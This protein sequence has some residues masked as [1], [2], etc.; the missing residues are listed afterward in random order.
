MA[1]NIEAVG[2]TSVT[3]FTAAIEAFIT[4]RALK[5]WYR[6]VRRANTH[7]LLPTLYR[8]P[9][10]TGFV[11]LAQLE[12][13]LIATFRHRSPP[14]VERLP[15][16]DLELLFLMQHHGMPT[17]LLDWSENPYAALFFAVVEGNHEENPEDSAVWVLDPVALNRKSL[18]H[19]SH[20]GGI[21]QISDPAAR[22][23][24][25]SSDEI[26]TRGNDNRATHEAMQ[27]SHL[28]R[29][30]LGPH[31]NRHDFASLCHHPRSC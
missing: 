26:G 15:S 24:R 5:L 23:F 30:V 7:T 20:R 19:M 4:E 28:R 1:A 21:I 27:L 10:F 2:V 14:F 16:D 25:P 13:E 22:G 3:E 9:T 6:G 12:Q 29:F 8:R 17:R 31:Q 11:E 18:M